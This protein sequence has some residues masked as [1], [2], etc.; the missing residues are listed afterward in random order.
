VLLPK[1]DDSRG[2]VQVE[3]VSWDACGR[4]L[5]SAVLSLHDSPFHPDW[6]EIVPRARK[7]SLVHIQKIVSK[8]AEQGVPCLSI[9]ASYESYAQFLEKTCVADMLVWK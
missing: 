9:S 3:R 6:L 2:S 5:E 7:E 1:V 4:I 8:L